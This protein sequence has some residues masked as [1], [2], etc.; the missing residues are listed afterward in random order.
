MFKICI[1]FCFDVV[2]GCVV[3]GVNFV[4]LVDVGDLV[5][6][7]KVYD[8]VGVDELCFFDIYVMYE[9]CGI[10]FDLVNCIVEEC[11]ML[12]IVGGG[13]CIFEDVWNLLLVGVDK[14]SFNL[15]VVVNFDVLID[16][17]LW[18]GS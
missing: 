9:N 15:V 14:V 8:V 18:F 17:V 10:M 11:F 2:D 6:V 7:V 12:L 13:V 5:E 3:K 1:I 4:G 16:V